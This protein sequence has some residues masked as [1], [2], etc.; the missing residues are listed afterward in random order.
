M[1][2]LSFI[3]F[4]IGI[5]MLAGVVVL[6]WIDTPDQRLLKWA[7]GFGHYYR[8]LFAELW[9]LLFLLGVM[10]CWPLA[11]WKFRR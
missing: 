2:W 5:W 3:G 7:S 8:G 9:G 10:F 11:W 1:S 4:A 6:S